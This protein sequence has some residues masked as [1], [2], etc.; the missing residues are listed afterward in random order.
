MSSPSLLRHHSA[1]YFILRTPLLSADLLASWKAP[2][3]GSPEAPSDADLTLGGDARS[4]LRHQLRDIIARPDLAEALALASPSLSARVPDWLSAPTSAR[5]RQIEERLIKYFLRASTRAIPFGLFAGWSV[6]VP[7]DG[8]ALEIDTA[9]FRRLSRPSAPCVFRLA[10]MLAREPAWR[11]VLRYHPN[12]C[13][14]TSGGRLAFVARD[15]RDP[16]WASFSRVTAEPSLHADAA[17][18]RARGGASFDELCAA[19]L[20]CDPDLDAGEARDFVEQMIDAQLLVDDLTPLTT[21][22]EPAQALAERLGTNA[23]ERARAFRAACDLLRADDAR[24]LGDPGRYERPRALLVEALSE[25]SSAAVTPGGE[26][27]LGS[28]GLIRVDLYNPQDGVTLDGKVFSELLRGLEVHLRLTPAT[29]ELRRFRSDFA[30]RYG[31]REVP[32]LEALD[33]EIGVGLDHGDAPESALLTGL[34]LEPPKTQPPPSAARGP[35]AETHLRER[36]FGLLRRGERELSLREG[37][38]TALTPPRRAEVPSSFTAFATLL[39]SDAEAI[40]RGDFLLE[41]RGMVAASPADYTSRFSHADERLAELARAELRAQ[42]E[43]EP[44]VLF[45]DLVHQPGASPTNLVLRPVLSGYEIPCAGA[46]GAASD[47]IL[48]LN[49]LR[50][51]VREDRLQL[52]WSGSHREVR[53]RVSTAHNYLVRRNLSV[54]RFLA[55]LADSHS[56]RSFQWDWGPLG[57]FPYLPRVTYGKCI[58]SPARWRVPR[59]RFEVAARG[60]ASERARAMRQLGAELELPSCVAIG[61]DDRRL[62]LD[63]DNPLCVDLLLAEAKRSPYLHLEEVL[64]QHHTLCVRDVRGQRFCHQ[65]VVPFLDRRRAPASTR[66]SER[67]SYPASGSRVFAPGSEWLYVKLYCGPRTAN[68]ALHA[69]VEPLARA[70][71]TRGW[72]DRWFFVRYG[73]P[74]W[75][76][77]VRFHGQSRQLLGELLP[78]LH[79][80]GA[81]WLDDGRI[82]S[83]QL[84]TYDREIERYGGPESMALCEEAF[85]ADSEACMALLA[86]SREDSGGELNV[87]HALVGIHR[88]LMDFGTRLDERSRLVT[89][90]AES[91]ATEFGIQGARESRVSAKCRQYRGRVE[92]LLGDGD[93][94]AAERLTRGAAAVLA[95]RSARLEPVVRALHELE[96]AGR[97][98]VPLGNVIA[99][100]S[101]MHANRLISSSARAH[102][103]MLYALLR[104]FYASAL[105]RRRRAATAGEVAP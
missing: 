35:G 59:S 82:K 48:S 46:S 33:E 1:R 69:I 13:L 78:L 84:D 4:A 63:L 16:D 34:W 76:L 102:E 54:Y 103:A 20:S 72:A 86:L 56:P 8:V 36:L 65:L 40:G 5:G 70:A 83:I 23:G 17:L 66:S 41:L 87:S 71:L 50:L 6:G 45:A 44:D 18:A 85:C 100:L 42:E 89:Q 53:V 93:P 3:D 49:E 80:R 94:A 10:A 47:R 14:S 29:D 62:P 101:H 64:Q 51:A 39:A 75:H 28:D 57:L 52:R 9:S 90:I 105:A 74:S 55:Q 32:L 99:A 79:E 24:P 21:G 30:E 97:L 7:G 27:A 98:G 77:R 43:R 26:R 38:L 19:I 96:R 22:P 92:L 31:A 73:D 67:R 2:T 60:Q 88:L 11:D 25:P 81:G 12:S 91:F 58:L 15:D 61:E 104:R 37:D 68:A 95:R